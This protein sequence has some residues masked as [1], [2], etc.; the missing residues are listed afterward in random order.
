MYLIFISLSIP[1]VLM[2]QTHGMNFDNLKSKLHTMVS[3]FRSPQLTQQIVLPIKDIPPTPEYSLNFM[4]INK[5]RKEQ[6]KTLAPENI[7]KNLV[8]RLIQWARLNPKAKNVNLWYDSAMTTPDAIENTKKE[9]SDHYTPLAKGPTLTLKDVRD[10]PEV[11][12]HPELFS[13]KTSVFF[14]TDLLRPIAAYE[15]LAG[16]D[17]KKPAAF[18]YADLDIIPLPQHKL[19][20]FYDILELK[21]YGIVMARGDPYGYENSFQIFGNKKKALDAVQNAL[22]KPQ[23]QVAYDSLS[24]PY[25]DIGDLAE[26]V[27]Q[28]YGNMF[29]YL[30][31][32]KGMGNFMQW[33]KSGTKIY[34]RAQDDIKPPINNLKFVPN[35]GMPKWPGN[36][37]SIP[38]VPTKKAPASSPMEESYFERSQPD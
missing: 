6:Q 36:Q 26:K 1:C 3:L 18:V 10:L 7:N 35:A 30:F 17:R 20:S 29:N 11:K 24:N 28:G 31:F 22:I 5:Q 27:Y 12:A 2:P 34:T 8:P 14:R 38:W 21:K 15:A 4:W 16:T 25:Y 19:L 23:I 13:E 9:I 32:L 33:Q 37:T